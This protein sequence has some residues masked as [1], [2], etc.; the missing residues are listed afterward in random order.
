MDIFD[1]VISVNDNIKE[2]DK[3]LY[4]YGLRQGLFIIIN[5]LTTIVLGY[6]FKNVWA[7]V[8][9]T[10]AYSPLRVYAGG[11]HTKTQL[12]CY[13]FSMFLTIA[14][15]YANRYIPGTSQ[16]II[17]ITIISCITVF[18]LSPVEDRNKPLDKVEKAVYRKRSLYVLLIEVILIALL[19]GIGSKRIALPVSI[20]L[21]ALSLMLIAGK[22]KNSLEAKS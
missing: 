22:I 1:K 13:I 14:V 10:I 7:V 19:L 20:S 2:E 16:N 18:S 11:Y 15:I 6:I 17:I 3:E 12:R 21:L 5:I 9:F 4:K 8:I